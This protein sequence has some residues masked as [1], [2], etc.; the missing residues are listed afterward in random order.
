MGFKANLTVCFVLMTMTTTVCAKLYTSVPVPAKR[1]ALRAV[2]TLTT[3][4]GEA[5]TDA[6]RYNTQ[7]TMCFE[8]RS[9]GH[10]LDTYRS[11]TELASVL[12][13]EGNFETRYESPRQYEQRLQD[14]PYGTTLPPYDNRFCMNV[15]DSRSIN[16]WLHCD[17]AHNYK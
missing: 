4:Y 10:D 16:E 1:Y 8:V 5:M 11:F 6:E 2:C 15:D 12:T 13:R 3:D 17:D 14:V 9:V 7:L